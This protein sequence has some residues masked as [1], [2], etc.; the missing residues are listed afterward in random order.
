MGI[1]LLLGWVV[2]AGTW[3]REEGG[4]QVSTQRSWCNREPQRQEAAAGAHA[5]PAAGPGKAWAAGRAAAGSAC[6]VEGVG[7]VVGPDVQYIHVVLAA[8]QLLK[9][10]WAAARQPPASSRQAQQAGGQAR[11]VLPCARFRS[12]A[13]PRPRHAAKDQTQAALQ[14]RRGRACFEGLGASA[15]AAPCV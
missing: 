14:C 4:R 12:A 1:C 11:T 5:G 6:L 7:R 2:G 3:V 9:P 8:V 13:C 15:V 10:C